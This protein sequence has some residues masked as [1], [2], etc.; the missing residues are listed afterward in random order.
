[1]WQCAYRRRV[2][3]GKGKEKKLCRCQILTGPDPAKAGPFS[4]SYRNLLVVLPMRSF[5]PVNKTRGRKTKSRARMRTK[6]GSG[7]CVELENC[8]QTMSSSANGVGQPCC[9]AFHMPRATGYCSAELPGRA[10]GRLGTGFVSSSVS[11]QTSQPLWFK[12][13]LQ[14][15]KL[16]ELRKLELV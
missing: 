4:W 1:M 8:R 15:W 14:V 3:L 16:L 10:V 9:W 6:W 13:R 7:L 5:F 12:F 11:S 2:S